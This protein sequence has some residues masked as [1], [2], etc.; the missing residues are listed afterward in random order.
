[1]SGMTVARIPPAAGGCDFT[2]GPDAMAAD[3][4]PV[5]ANLIGDR[6][7]ALRP[8]G[9][10]KWVTNLNSATGHTRLAGAWTYNAEVLIARAA[11]TLTHEYAHSTWYDRH[12][13]RE[14][15]GPVNATAL[16][17]GSFTAAGNVAVTVATAPGW[18][19][20]TTWKN[21]T[22]GFAAGG[23]TTAS[24]GDNGLTSIYPTQ[25]LKWQG[26]A[27]APT[28][29]SSTA[30]MGGADLAVYGQRLWMAGG[31]PTL[32][33]GAGSA[34]LTYEGS[35]L[36]FSKLDDYTNWSDDGQNPN[37][38]VVDSNEQDGLTA[39]APMANGMLVFMSNS[40]HRLTGTGSSSWRVTRV[41]NNIGCIDAHSVV[42]M[43]DGV[44]FMGRDGLYVTDGYTVTYLS[45]PVEPLLRPLLNSKC[46][47]TQVEA[48]N[49][50]W[51]MVQQTMLDTAAV[52]QTAWTQFSA[53]FNRRTGAWVMHD[54]TAGGGFQAAS[55]LNN[56]LGRIYSP[57]ANPH[58]IL[59]RGDGV[60]VGVNDATLFRGDDVIDGGSNG[61]DVLYDDGGGA[62]TFTPIPCKWYARPVR[63]A[64]PL[65]MS[66]F[67]KLMIDYSM[68]TAAVAMPGWSATVVD[69]YGTTL[70]AATSLTTDPYS[71]TPGANAVYRKRFQV[72]AFDEAVEAQVRITF[73]GTTHA[74]AAM[75]GYAAALYE[76]AIAFQASRLRPTV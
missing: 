39:L 34:S 60:V 55:S 66:Q 27:G 25:L 31:K 62:S 37:R 20:W 33:N 26:G 48:L 71:A 76:A 58:R 11:R 74:N 19:G 42:A 8:R 70:V 15:N 47:R 43:D 56:R 13:V 16:W 64:A 63:L 21:T 54:V 28:A 24:A 35:T 52:G 53:L 68:L 38:I 9:P 69:G 12:L 50:D 51:L 4:A 10:W 45:Q 73:A 7:G 17:N 36:F 29:V 18:G 6:Q 57:S 2:S 30:P 1:M 67:Q 59:R 32:L 75:F 40:I 14:S 23:V 61:Y 72:E 49:Y 65:Q 46:A 41:A 5:V 22:F 3:R 44:Y